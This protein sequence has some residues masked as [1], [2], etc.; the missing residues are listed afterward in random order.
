MSFQ[1]EQND[2]IELV[3]K[4]PAFVLKNWLCLAFENQMPCAMIHM[5]LGSRFQAGKFRIKPL[6]EL[7]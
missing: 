4:C 6:V 7:N 1:L 3:V 2:T 5:Y